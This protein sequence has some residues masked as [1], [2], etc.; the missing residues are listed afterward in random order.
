VHHG[1]LAF[2]SLHPAAVGDGNG[3]LVEAVLARD[4]NFLAGRRVGTVG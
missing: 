1:E 2:A 4:A 3:L